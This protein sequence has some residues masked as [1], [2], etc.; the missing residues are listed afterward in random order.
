MC[1]IPGVPKKYTS[2]KVIS[3]KFFLLRMDKSQNFVSFVRQDLNLNFETQFFKVG[4]KL[5][6]L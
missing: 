1:I 6:E 3:F 5:T 2:L 4:Q